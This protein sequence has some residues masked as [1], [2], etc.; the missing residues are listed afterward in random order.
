M[1]DFTAEVLQVTSDGR[2]AE[3]VF[4]FKVPL[5]DET[6]RWVYFVGG[7]MEE[8]VPPPMGES[9]QIDSVVLKDFF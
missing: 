1:P 6:L 5:E 9:V 3:V 4:E 2:P 7:R 8:F